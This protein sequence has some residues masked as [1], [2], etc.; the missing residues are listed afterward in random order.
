MDHI[1]KCFNYVVEVCYSLLKLC[2][3]ITESRR[4]FSYEK[5]KIELATKITT[6]FFDAVTCNVRYKVSNLFR[7]SSA[8]C[9]KL[10]DFRITWVNGVV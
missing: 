10:Y 6:M 7:W 9:N 4:I 3:Y 2:K 8:A 1:S 5:K